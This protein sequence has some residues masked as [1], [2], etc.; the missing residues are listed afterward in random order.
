MFV[1]YL[2]MPDHNL[3]NE[4]GQILKNSIGDFEKSFQCLDAIETH[5]NRYVSLR[6][7]VAISLLDVFDLIEICVQPSM[8]AS[9]KSEWSWHCY[10]R[11][12]QLLVSIIECSRRNL[13]D[14]KEEIPGQFDFLIE[15]FK[16]EWQRR[17]FLVE[18]G[19][20]H[21]FHKSLRRLKKIC[22]SYPY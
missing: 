2:Q 5:I 3:P 18:K 14:N 7:E 8:V 20:C 1:D 6:I 10:N 21:E 15:K 4:L 19:G 16:Y 17:R 12:F 22:P 13:E 11:Y 9:Q